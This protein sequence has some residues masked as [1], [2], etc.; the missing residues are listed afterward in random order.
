MKALAFNRSHSHGFTL[1]EVLVALAVIAIAMA[2]IIKTTG[3]GA[4]NTAYLRDK[5]LAHW[6]AM[7]QLAE[8]RI[9]EEPPSTGRKDGQ[10]ELAGRKW[11]WFAE[12]EK[13]ADRDIRRVELSVH[14]E[15]DRRSPA[16]TVLT[17]FLGTPQTRPAALPPLA[18]PNQADP[19]QTGAD[20]PGIG[21]GD[22]L[23]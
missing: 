10:Q 18:N 1:L 3:A 2:A 20:Q 12:I 13:T 19:A 17:G 16:V 5:T 8:M 22:G 7:N 23:Q 11:F 15:D 6:V 4:A 21:Q 9:A 14:L